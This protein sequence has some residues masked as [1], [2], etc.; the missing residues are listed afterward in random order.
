M[1]APFTGG[2]EGLADVVLAMLSAGVAVGAYVVGAKRP[3]YWGVGTF[4]VGFLGPQIRDSLS[5]QKSQ[6]TSENTQQRTSLV[7]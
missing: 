2:M 6:V 5:G 3:L 4:A 7:K 1:R